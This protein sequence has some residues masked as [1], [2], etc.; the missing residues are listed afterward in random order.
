MLTVTAAMNRVERLYHYERFDR[1]RLE[2]LLATSS[3]FLSDTKGFND[4]WDCRP[5]FDLGRLEDA[6][7]YE[8]QVQWFR[9]VDRKHNPHRS[10][11]ELDKRASRLRNDRLF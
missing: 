8:R 2:Q 3:L 1:D 9:Q 10:E 7:F 11:E 4:P 6:A 5:F